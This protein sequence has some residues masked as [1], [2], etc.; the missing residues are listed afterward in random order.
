[1]AW[2][3]EF[4]GKANGT[5]YELSLDELSLKGDSGI[6]EVGVNVKAGNT[7][8]LSFDANVS[9]YVGQREGVAGKFRM[10]YAF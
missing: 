6:V 1:M 10:N 5:T 9:G 8:R 4:S 2:E 3:H 7:G